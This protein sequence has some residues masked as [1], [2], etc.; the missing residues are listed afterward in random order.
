M[1]ATG[2]L[3]AFV[4]FAVS[5]SAWAED[6]APR[7]PAPGEPPP[8]SPVAPYDP[9]APG[10]GAV[11]GLQP[12]GPEPLP[13]GSIGT[14]APPPPGAGFVA[15][16]SPTPQECDRCCLTGSPEWMW[17]VYAP[18]GLFRIPWTGEYNPR[19]SNDHWAFF[20]GQS[21][22]YDSNVFLA[23]EGDEEDDFVS[24]TTVG[25]SY[26]REGRA[27]HVGASLAGTYDWYLDHDDLNFFN[28]FGILDAGW[29][30][31]CAYVNVSDRLSYSQDPWIVLEGTPTE[32]I[33][34]DRDLEPYWQND[35]GIRAGY[36]GCRW[37]AEVA[38]NL[39][40]FLSDG[41]VIEA[42]DHMDH[43][44]SARVDYY[45]TAK[46][47]LGA[48]AG[49]R[50]ITYDEGSH[51]D[52]TIYSVGGT[53]S[54]RP[55]AKFGI[56]GAVGVSRAEDGDEE[57]AYVA[58]VYATYAATHKLTIDLGYRRQ[59]EPSLGAQAQLLDTLYGR[60]DWAFAPS[61]SLDATA[62][63]AIGDVID[64]LEEG[65]SDYTTI[66]GGLALHHV[67][68]CW[69]TGDL[70]YVYRTQDTD[71]GIDYQVHRVTVGLTIVL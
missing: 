47:S 48:M 3:A 38:Y 70:S 26:R 33:V 50:F 12:A 40:L 24:H 18:A 41:D 11:E 30:G 27:F 52:F 19:G 21:I 64:P 67:F 34:A 9:A 36:E 6:Y 53:F 2:L 37:R 60:A 65:S 28:V 56:Q 46:L 7:V 43:G 42:F 14:P 66:Y 10:Y 49:V 71:D 54:W 59:Y 20:G 15:V 58:D 22:T 16:P 62:G 45:L 8:T 44:F 1:R 61:W 32:V 55:T 39:G 57:T 17:P 69:L 4:A 51:D 35:F 23:E 25:V 63:V 29:R 5:G 13:P 68:N 31:A